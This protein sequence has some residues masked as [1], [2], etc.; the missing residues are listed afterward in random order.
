MTDDQWA[1]LAGKHATGKKLRS[2]TGR[3]GRKPKPTAIRI[4]EGNRGGGRIVVEPPTF[5]P[6]EEPP[7]WFNEQQRAEW[8]YVVRNAPLGVL[9]NS[10]RGVLTVYVI[11]LDWYRRAIEAA[12]N[13][14]L[15]QEG[16]LA[17]NPYISIAQKQA[18]IIL[19]AAS[20]LGFSPTSRPR[21]VSP[22]GD[23]FDQLNRSEDDLRA[24]L[25]KLRTFQ[26]LLDDEPLGEQRN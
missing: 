24:E 8:D 13:M 14:G 20:E 18:A 5:G 25:E 9:K 23:D 17:A 6:L 15:V 3:G 11:A 26:R 16:D 7:A 4:A 12:N 19:R 1:K 22:A 2:S 10:D 21:L